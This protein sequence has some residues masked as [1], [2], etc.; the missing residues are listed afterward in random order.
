MGARGHTQGER[1]PGSKVV[2]KPYMYMHDTNIINMHAYSAMVASPPGPSQI[3][4]EKR[5]A[6]NIER[7]GT[8]LHFRETADVHSLRVHCNFE[9]C[10]LHVC[11]LLCRCREDL[12]S[13]QSSHDDQIRGMSQELVAKDL[14]LQTLEDMCDKLRED[15]RKRDSDIEQ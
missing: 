5:E 2:I 6:C 11:I 15:M 8:R 4:S 3:F 14:K 9:L 7:L 10:N 1:T 12:A 13:C